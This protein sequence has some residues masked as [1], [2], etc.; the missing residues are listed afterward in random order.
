MPLRVRKFCSRTNPGEPGTPT[1]VSYPH[2]IADGSI[3][4]GQHA[5][6][7]GQEHDPFFVGQ[8]PSADD[9][10]LPELSL[11]A[12]LVRQF[13]NRMLVT[14]S[15]CEACRLPLA[16]EEYRRIGSHPA[17]HIRRFRSGSVART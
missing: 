12:N 9:F 1:F 4:P 5:S 8:D 11:P 6:F 15:R 10:R 3:T 7:L 14:R 13:S 2:V 16:Q 17:L